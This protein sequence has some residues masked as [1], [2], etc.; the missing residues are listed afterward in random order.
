MLSCM[1][2]LSSSLVYFQL[3]VKT[4]LFEFTE[5]TNNNKAGSLQVPQ[6]G[7]RQQ[8]WA[9]DSVCGPHCAWNPQP[10]EVGTV[11]LEPSNCYFTV[12]RANLT[13]FP[14]THCSDNGSRNSKCRWTQQQWAMHA[15]FYTQFPHVTIMLVSKHK[16]VIIPKLQL[17]KVRF[18]EMNLSNYHLDHRC[19]GGVSAHH[20]CRYPGYHGGNH[21]PESPKGWV[22]S[23][24]I[25][26]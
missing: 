4:E 2:K 12:T 3:I 24:R 16:A 22:C 6:S 13:P 25:G 18:A 7:G 1:L 15:T 21:V 10:R 11:T 5:G 26:S 8:Q 23:A 19:P 14:G 9:D 17:G 20:I